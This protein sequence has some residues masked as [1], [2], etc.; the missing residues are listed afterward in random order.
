MGKQ[1]LLLKDVKAFGKGS[2]CQHSWDIVMVEFSGEAAEVL[3]LNP[4]FSLDF[5]AKAAILKDRSIV[6][7]I[8]SALRKA[9][10]K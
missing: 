10:L 6:D 8:V 4:K 5:Y 7:N 3:S 9:G 2:I 1:G